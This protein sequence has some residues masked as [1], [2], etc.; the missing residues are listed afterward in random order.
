MHNTPQNQTASIE[1]KC[2]IK[3]ER[4]FNLEF[5]TKVFIEIVRE[6]LTLLELFAN[7]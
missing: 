1:K 3:G 7:Y 5:N 6:K 2:C 4:K